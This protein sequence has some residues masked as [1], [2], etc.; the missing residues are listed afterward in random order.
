MPPLAIAL[1]VPALSLAAQ[2][3]A[4]ASSV[5]GA[6]FVDATGAYL[7][8]AAFSGSC[9]GPATLTVPPP[10]AP[11]SGSCTAPA[12]LPVTIPPPPG[13]DVRTV[14]VTS[15]SVGTCGGGLSCLDC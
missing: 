1:L 14:S 11:F 7:A 6:A 15:S 9:H 5:T 4:A 8:D 13:D 10:R 3:T 2:P 12:T